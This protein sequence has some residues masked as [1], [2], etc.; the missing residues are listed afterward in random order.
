VIVSAIFAFVIS[1]FVAV[2][3]P[4]IFAWIA[5]FLL[6][7]DKSKIAGFS[8]ALGIFVAGA[9][10]AGL[11]AIDKGAMLAGVIVGSVFVWKQFVQK[12]EQHG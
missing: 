10:S 1:A 2:I 8:F 4:L 5:S 12:V 9:G 6:P 11:S 3:N 7:E